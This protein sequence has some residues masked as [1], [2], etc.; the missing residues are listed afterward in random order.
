M[1]FRSEASAVV[2][3]LGAAAYHAKV[4]E[5]A[6]TAF[7]IAFVS[8]EVIAELILVELVNEVAAKL[9][10]EVQKVVE[11]LGTRNRA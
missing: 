3:G 4:S 11:V 7:A 10:R 9:V 6:C 5:F 2:V 8:L 1:D